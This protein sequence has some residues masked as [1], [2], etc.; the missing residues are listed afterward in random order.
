MLI[1]VYQ[2]SCCLYSESSTKGLVEHGIHRELT[3]A[4]I[5]L[6]NLVPEKR[7]ERKQSTIHFRLRRQKKSEAYA[8]MNIDPQ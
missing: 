6:K 8:V 3:S 5:V 2:K 7:E 1:A 4:S